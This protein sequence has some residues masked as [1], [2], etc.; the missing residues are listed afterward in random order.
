MQAN[1]DHCPEGAEGGENKGIAKIIGGM[2]DSF[3]FSV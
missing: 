2:E 3:V 1:C